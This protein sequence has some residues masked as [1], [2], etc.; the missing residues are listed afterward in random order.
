MSLKYYDVTCKPRILFLRYFYMLSYFAMAKTN[1]S[2]I[3]L[4]RNKPILTTKHNSV[5]DFSNGYVFHLSSERTG[6]SPLK[7]VGISL[8]ALFALCVIV[9]IGFKCCRKKNRDPHVAVVHSLT[10][11]DKSWLAAYEKYSIAL[12]LS[13]E[14][15]LVLFSAPAP[16]S[17][18]KR[19]QVTSLKS[20]SG[21]LAS[22]NFPLPYDEYVWCTWKFDMDSD[23]KIKLSFDFFNVSCKFDYVRV[24]NKKYC[25][26]EKPPSINLTTSDSVKFRSSVFIG[27]K[28]CRKK[29]RD[30]HVA[31]VHSLTN[32]VGTEQEQD[33][34]L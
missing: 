4:S 8:G 1:F 31:V 11:H 26:S 9:F 3:N 2:F 14:N 25:G 17:C 21:S 7:I 6:L 15:Y 22:Y 5:Q 13:Y 30:P 20:K 28:C 19:N 12:N 29:N 23:Y 34:T 33:T 32:D 27:F 18:I 16:Y 24:L 10:N